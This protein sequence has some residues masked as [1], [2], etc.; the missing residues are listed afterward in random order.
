[1]FFTKK[2]KI[3]KYLEQKAESDKN[4]FDFLLCN[5][6]DGTLKT[7]LETNITKCYQFSLLARRCVHNYISFLLFYFYFHT[8]LMLCSK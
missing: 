7:D 5:Y 4:A 8:F 1:M 3:Q 2:K 6:L